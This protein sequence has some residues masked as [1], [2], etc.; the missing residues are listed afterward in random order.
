M[1]AKK[2]TYKDIAQILGVSSTTVHRALTGKG[3]VGDLMTAKIRKLA[4][5]MGYQPNHRTALFN[6]SSFNL[7]VVFPEPTME[8]RYYYLSLWT[9]VRRFFQEVS[10]F[11]VNASEFP[12]PL[13]PESNGA[14]LKDIYE[15]HRNSLDGLITIAV[16][17]SQSSYFLEKLSGEGIPIVTVG[18][19]IYKNLSLCSVMACDEM[20]GSLAAELLTAFQPAGFSGRILVTGNPV[21]SFSMPDQYHNACG[22]ERYISRYAPGC[23]L[24][25]AYSPDSNA[26]G[27]QIC[28]YLEQYEDIHAIYSTSARNTVLICEI[29]EEMGLEGKLKLIGNDRFPESMDYLKKG[30]LTA[31]IDKKISGQSYQAAKILFDYAAKGEYPS[32]P[33]IRIPPD[34]VMKGHCEG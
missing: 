9:G 4:E 24:L 31:I 21:G 20:V 23:S 27:A 7:A 15:N 13:L 29:A 18:A 10:A 19:D 30:V 12:Y 17:N 22:F 8:N 25:T 34:V 26:A 33:V 28:S 16:E 5:E 1:A 6:K 3:G 14:V 11:H 2:A 32:S